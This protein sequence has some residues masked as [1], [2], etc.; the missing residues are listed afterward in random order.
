MSV[1]LISPFKKINLVNKYMKPE[2]AVKL[3]EVLETL[4]KNKKLLVVAA[5]LTVAL[6][7]FDF[8]ILG[9]ENPNDWSVL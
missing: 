8:G 1:K 9:D 5:V 6:A 7:K 3:V 2:T 4:N